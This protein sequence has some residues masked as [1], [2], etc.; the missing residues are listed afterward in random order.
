MRNRW[1]HF[2]VRCTVRCKFI[3]DDRSRHERQ[4][5]QQLS[6]EALCRFRIP[7]LLNQDV[8]DF[9]ILIHRAPQ[10]DQRAV[11]LQEYLVEMPSIAATSAATTQAPCVRSTE[12]QRPQANRFVRNLDPPFQHHFLD[13]TKAEAEPEVQPR[14]VGDDFGGKSVPAVRRFNVHPTIAS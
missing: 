4:A 6:E 5:L 12:F 7:P 8:E 9:A 11:D 13:V 2:S 14:A 10:V 1:H 3:R